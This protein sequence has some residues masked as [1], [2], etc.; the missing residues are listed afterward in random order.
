MGAR[1]CQVEGGRVLDS[2]AVTCHE[3]YPDAMRFEELLQ[4]VGEEPLFETGLLL[5]GRV[6][7][8]DVQRQLSRWADAGKLL[9]VRRGL[10]T[11]APPYRKTN[12]HPFL[13]GNRLVRGSYVSLQSALSHH[14]LI[15]EGVPVTTSVTTGRPGH[16]QTPLGIYDFRHIQADWLTGYRRIQVAAGQEA[17]VATPEKALL[18]LIYLEPGADTPSYLEELRLQHLD[19]LDLDALASQAAASGRP[20]LIRA[21]EWIL[22]QAEID[23]LEYEIL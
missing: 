1:I 18:D 22:R 11:L 15:P 6:D 5:A 16:W 9:Q 14:G 10:Y 7:P 23:A 20:K 4:A 19:R 12:P 8:G 17:F 2:I 13:V 3:W 21:A